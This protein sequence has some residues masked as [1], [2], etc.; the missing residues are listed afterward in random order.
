MIFEQPYNGFAVF[1]VF[2][3]I[4][5]HSDLAPILVP[6]LI[7]FYVLWGALGPCWEALEVS[8][9]VLDGIGGSGVKVVRND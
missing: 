6:I 9:P 2:S 7:P 1:L 3:K 8:G 4:R 5:V